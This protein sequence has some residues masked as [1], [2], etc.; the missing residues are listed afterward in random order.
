M[1]CC[2]TAAVS[3]VAR[4]SKTFATFGVK[5]RCSSSVVTRYVDFGG[6]KLEIKYSRVRRLSKMNDVCGFHRQ[7]MRWA[8]TGGS[9]LA[10]KRFHVSSAEHNEEFIWFLV[11]AFSLQL[12]RLLGRVRHRKREWKLRMHPGWAEAREE[13]LLFAAC[14]VSATNAVQKSAWRGRSVHA[15]LKK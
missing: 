15:V 3:R 11:L 13:G 9:A 2:S 14:A 1:S 8:Q 7:R 10:V 5:R 4:S 6:A 12:R